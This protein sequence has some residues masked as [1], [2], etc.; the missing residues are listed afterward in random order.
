V[1]EQTTKHFAR[2]S[3]EGDVRIPG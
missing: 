2:E 1:L 3:A